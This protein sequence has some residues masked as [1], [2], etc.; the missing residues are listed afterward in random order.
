MPQGILPDEVAMIDLQVGA[1]FNARFPFR[2]GYILQ[3]R[4]MD[5]KQRALTSIL[6]I[7]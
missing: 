1:A 5:S 3:P 7:F 6:L 4:V 2:D